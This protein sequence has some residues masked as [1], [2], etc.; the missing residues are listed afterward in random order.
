M[1]ALTGFTTAAGAA[2][3]TPPYAPAGASG[4]GVNAPPIG[5]QPLA[6]GLWDAQ[7]YEMPLPAKACPQPPQSLAA[8]LALVNSPIML[9]YYGLPHLS[10]YSG[11]LAKWQKIVG[12]MKH[13][14]CQEA[15]PIRNGKPMVYSNVS[16]QG[17]WSGFGNHHYR[18]TDHYAGDGYFLMPRVSSSDGHF[19]V[20]SAWVGIGGTDGDA[21]DQAGWEATTTSSGTTYQWFYEYVPPSGGGSGATTF[22]GSFTPSDQLYFYCN[23]TGTWTLENI[24]NGEYHLGGTGN[25]SSQESVEFIME[26]VTGNELA[27]FGSTYFDNVEWENN[28]NQWDDLLNNGYVYQWLLQNSHGQTMITLPSWPQKNYTPPGDYFDNT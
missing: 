28:N 2:A 11:D 13:Q 26:R 12:G 9:D 23:S 20:V 22:S 21:L 18:A 17:L 16:A 14:L 10:Q 5:S 7:N 19:Q 1:M 24:T 15:K 25:P 8:R 6:P 3:L 27:S 4:T